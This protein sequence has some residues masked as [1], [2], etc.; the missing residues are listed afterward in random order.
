MS[1]PDRSWKIGDYN[2]CGNHCEFKEGICSWCGTGGYCC[3]GNPDF[4]NNGDCET[5][6]LEP[7]IKYWQISGNEYPMCVIPAKQNG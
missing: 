4:F 1:F 5:A 3:S 6:Q 7:L 2:D